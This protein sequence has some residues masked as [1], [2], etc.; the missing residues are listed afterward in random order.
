ML[1]SFDGFQSEDGGGEQGRGGFPSYRSLF[2]WGRP[3]WS[4]G[5]YHCGAFGERLRGTA[6]VTEMEITRPF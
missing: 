5:Y 4:P 2:I 6:G 3:G 1:A